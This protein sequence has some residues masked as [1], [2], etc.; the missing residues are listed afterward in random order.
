MI[1]WN[2]TTKNNYW[3]GMVARTLAG[4]AR[5]WEKTERKKL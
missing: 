1:K 2:L 3:N 5:D 4:K